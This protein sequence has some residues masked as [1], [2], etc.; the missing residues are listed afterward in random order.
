[1]CFT[2]KD[3][4]DLFQAK[5]EFMQ[6]SDGKYLD[7]VTYHWFEIELS[8][9]GASIIYYVVAYYFFRKHR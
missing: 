6:F 5:G 9:F 2:H 8:S 4:W 3:D 7:E 1:M